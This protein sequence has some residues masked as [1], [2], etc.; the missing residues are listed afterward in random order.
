MP[1]DPGLAG[2]VGA[3]VGA[4]V[5]GG[6]AVGS[7]WLQHEWSGKDARAQRI[8]THAD[9]AAIRIL[10]A[11]E[12]L[13]AMCSGLSFEFRD[14]TNQDLYELCHKM[15]RDALVLPDKTL[16]DRIAMFT[17]VI[18]HLELIAYV[19]RNPLSQMAFVLYRAGEEVLGAYRRNEDL[20]DLDASEAL[21][22]LSTY[23]R[24]AE[25]AEAQIERELAVSEEDPCR[26]RTD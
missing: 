21:K 8:E 14:F 18:W 2:I 20:P 15:E 19:T 17:K 3:A 25:E 13:R 11:L 26:N 10:D 22:K 1:I 6:V 23:Y 24:E 16:R 4:V 12:K 7:A 9:E 5:G